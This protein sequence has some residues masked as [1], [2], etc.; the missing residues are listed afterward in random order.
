MKRDSFLDK[1]VGFTFSTEEREITEDELNKLYEMWGD[2]ENL[3]TDDDFARSADMNFQGRIVAGLFLAGVMLPKLDMLPGAGFAYDAAM[4]GMNDVKFISPAYPGDRLRLEGEL[5][6]K[7]TTS[8]GHVL[9]EWKWALVKKDGTMVAS[10][11]NTELFP[12][13]MAE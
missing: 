3:F 5:T 13:S 6:G 11:T 7:R 9:V 4:V 1:E 2:T 12:R 10:G 8:K